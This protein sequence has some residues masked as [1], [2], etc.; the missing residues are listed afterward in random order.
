M[1]RQHAITEPEQRDEYATGWAHRELNMMPIAVTQTDTRQA[2]LLID[3][4]DTLSS[5]PTSANPRDTSQSTSWVAFKPCQ[6]RAGFAGCNHGQGSGLPEEV[7]QELAEAEL[8]HTVARYQILEKARAFSPSTHTRIVDSPCMGPVMGSTI[9]DYGGESGPSNAFM[10]S[11]QLF[12]HDPM[13]NDSGS[14]Q[15]S[16]LGV[17]PTQQ[18]P[19]TTFDLNPSQNVVHDPDQT[20]ITFPDIH[21]DDPSA[22]YQAMYREPSTEISMLLRTPPYNR[23]IPILDTGD[24]AN[25]GSFLEATNPCHSMQSVLARQGVRSVAVDADNLEIYPIDDAAYNTTSPLTV[26]AWN[27]NIASRQGHPFVAVSPGLSPYPTIEQSA[28]GYADAVETAAPLLYSQPM[29]VV[30][31]IGGDQLPIAKRKTCGSNN[32]GNEKIVFS[33][34]LDNIYF[35]TNPEADRE[36]KKHQ[37]KRR[38]VTT[39][40]SW[41]CFGCRLNKRKCETSIDG[42]CLR[43]KDILNKNAY[44]TPVQK[45][46]CDVRTKFIDFAHSCFTDVLGVSNPTRLSPISDFAIKRFGSTLPTTVDNIKRS[47]EAMNSMVWELVERLRS[48]LDFMEPLHVRKLFPQSSILPVLWS[49]SLSIIKWQKVIGSLWPS[50]KDDLYFH[51]ECHIH[52]L[53]PISLYLLDHME[54]L[55][56][57]LVVALLLNI[58]YEEILVMDESLMTSSSVKDHLQSSLADR[59]LHIYRSLFPTSTTGKA[60]RT[61][62]LKSR[63]VA[64]R[65]FP[66]TTG[67]LP[68][69][70]RQF[71]MGGIAWN[72]LQHQKTSIRSDENLPPENAESHCQKAPEHSFPML[73]AYVPAQLFVILGL[74][75]ETQDFITD[76]QWMEPIEVCI[77]KHLKIYDANV[78]KEILDFSPYTL[79]IGSKALF[80]EVNK[81]LAD[82]DLVHQVFPS[83][84]CMGKEFLHRIV[85]MSIGYCE[86]LLEY[87]RLWSLS[88]KREVTLTEFIMENRDLEDKYVQFIVDGSESSKA[89]LC[90]D[91][92]TRFGRKK[93]R[94]R[95]HAAQLIQQ[96]QQEGQEV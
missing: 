49:Y 61:E 50:L 37:P 38:R 51:K 33:C 36:R 2:M 26:P 54:Y 19:D 88:Q 70:Y 27:G 57:Y 24:H 3:G 10:H 18:I 86:I 20:S 48:F 76:S 62:G 31:G 55:G 44:R 87:V 5:F 59:I 77:Q 40:A 94:Q 6:Q 46:T 83:W 69:H 11:H 81:I 29:T 73:K 9:T 68:S 80:Y 92:F 56:D 28:T 93:P 75:T 78:Q 96:V 13:P 12:N 35:H 52:T 66:F 63:A 42:L 34:A 72:M 25:N 47:R 4:R 90:A 16:N 67:L 22:P 14:M 84:H 95:G 23:M 21:V 17:W 60:S 64:L 74:D 53:R 7:Q 89:R 79:S 8:R 82:E 1:D 65:L 43:C 32:A 41:S 45:F 85:M 15:G 39:K 30:S 91:L 58:W 71:S